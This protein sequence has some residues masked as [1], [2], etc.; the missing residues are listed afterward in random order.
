V[1]SSFSLL[2][3]ILP[4]VISTEALRGGE[5]SVWMLFLG[6]FCERA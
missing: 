5:T 2:D 3:A 4:F 6:D 1:F